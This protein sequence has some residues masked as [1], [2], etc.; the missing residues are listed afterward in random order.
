M[1][2]LLLTLL[3]TLPALPAQAQTIRGAGARP[4]AEWNQARRGGGR[5]FEA[6]QWT[7][8]Y[9][10]A[11][12]VTNAAATRGL[13]RAT[14]EKGTFAA[15]DGYCATHPNDMLWSAVKSALA[16]SHGA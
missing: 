5:D 12:T 9:I 11:V 6:Q 16:A 4:C 10:S 8:G 1:R 14:D 7:L 15:I 3:L 2:T 13:L